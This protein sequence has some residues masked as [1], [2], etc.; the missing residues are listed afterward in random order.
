MCIVKKAIYELEKIYK[1]DYICIKLNGLIQTTQSSVYRHI[2]RQ[3][4]IVEK[5]VVTDLDHGEF[6]TKPLIF[7][8]YNFEEL[9]KHCTDK[10]INNLLELPHIT[11]PYI[12][13]NRL[14]T[15]E[16]FKELIK[17]LLKIDNSLIP[18]ANYCSMFNDKV[19]ELLKT[20]SFK[21]IIKQIFDFSAD[22]DP[23]CKL[24]I[25][26]PFLV[27]ENFIQSDLDYGI[28]FN[29]ILQ[30]LSQT[31]IWILIAIKSLILLRD[32]DTFNFEIVYDACYDYVRGHTSNNILLKEH[33]VLAEYEFLHSRGLLEY[34]ADKERNPSKRLMMSRVLLLPNQI[35]DIVD[36][37][38]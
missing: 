21:K 3:L 7:I 19:Q 20:E 28:K 38:I 9:K 37:K 35:S 17:N 8:I 14:E 26:S 16:D 27:L 12:N 6:V 11:R 24:S 25:D 4:G 23:V 29:D 10:F 5:G 31:Q 13:L 32:R 1:D 30:D 33:I 18:D 36:N 2:V 34:V 22:F 15:I